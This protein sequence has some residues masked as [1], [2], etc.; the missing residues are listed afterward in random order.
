MAIVGNDSSD[1]EKSEF[2]REKLPSSMFQ[3]LS[4]FLSRAA[5]CPAS[6]A[7]WYSSFAR[8]HL[9][10]IIDVLP[11][12]LFSD[13][14]RGIIFV[15]GGGLGV[16]FWGRNGAVVDLWVLA[17]LWEPDGFVQSSSMNSLYAELEGGRCLSGAGYGVVRL[18][19]FGR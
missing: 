18:N 15:G 5:A 6:I 8:L 16:D 7:N 3:F 11:K 14:S 17:N 2:F 10:V 13:G 1:R 9:F 19:L 12:L 4:Y